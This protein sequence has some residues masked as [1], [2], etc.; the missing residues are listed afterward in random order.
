MTNSWDRRCF[1]NN[2][3]ITIFWL[4]V[5]SWER[6]VYLSV[7]L[8]FQLPAM[9]SYF[10]SP[11]HLLGP[12]IVGQ[13]LGMTLVARN[14]VNWLSPPICSFVSACIVNYSAITRDDTD[15]FSIPHHLVAPQSTPC[16]MS[17]HDDQLYRSSTS[18]LRSLSI[19]ERSQSD[20][21]AALTSFRYW[22]GWMNI[23][24]GFAIIAIHPSRRR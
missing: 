10:R 21:T 12:G 6:I 14:G 1:F 8:S 22:N 2:Q 7:C 3:I 16:T 4:S 15:R 24:H 20:D 18:E 11:H 23:E 13:P 5:Y 19:P 17:A 9:S